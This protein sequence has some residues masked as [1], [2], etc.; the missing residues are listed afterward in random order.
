MSNRYKLCVKKRN[1]DLVPIR[2]D[3]IT[4][5]INSL[6]EMKPELDSSIDPFEITQK[7]VAMIKSDISTSEIDTFTAEIC[8]AKVMEHYHYG[9]LAARLVIDDHHKTL[10]KIGVN[11]FSDCIEKLHKNIDDNGNHCSIISDLIYNFVMENKDFVDSIPKLEND[12]LFDYFGFKSMQKNYLLKVNEINETKEE[13]GVIV[14]CPQYMFLRVALAIHIDNGQDFKD[15]I[16]ETYT[17]LSNKQYTHATPTLYNA[18]TRF[19]NYISC[20]LLGMEDSI[21]GIFKCIGDSAIIS[22]WAGGIGINVCDIRSK[23]SYISK[24]NGRSDGVPKMLEVFNKAAKYANQCFTPD[25]IIYTKNGPKEIKD[26]VIGDEVVTL[27]GEFKPVMKVFSRNVSEKIREIEMKNGKIVKCTDVHQIY[28][29]LD[30]EKFDY[31]DAKELTNN[32]FTFYPK[33]TLLGESFEESHGE[34]VRNGSIDYTGTVY[35]LNIKDNHNYLTEMGLVHNSGK[36]A[37]S[38]A[39]YMEPWHSDIFEFLDAKIPDGDISSK[40]VDLFYGMWIPDVF[41]E[42]VVSDSDW[43]LMSPSECPGLTDAYDIEFSKLYSKYISM[44]K[45]RKKIKAR[46]LWHKIILCQIETGNPYMLFKDAVNRKSNHKNIGTIKNSNLCVAPETRIL[47]KEGYLPISELKDKQI[48]VWNGKQW[49][50]T[51]VRQTGTDQKLLKVTFSNGTILHCT[52]YHKFYI[53]ENDQEI[54]VQTT[55]LNPGMKLIKYN[56]PSNGDISFS[57]TLGTYDEVYSDMLKYQRQ[58][59]YTYIKKYNEENETENNYTLDLTCKEKNVSVKSV[60]DINRISDTY[61]FTEPLENKGMFE[62]IL[63]GNCSEIVEYS[64]TK[65]YAC[66]VLSSLVLP[67]FVSESGVFDYNKLMDTTRIIVRNLDRVIDIN[68]YPV[69]ETKLSNMSERPLG[70]GVQ[71]L[72]DVFFK[73]GIPF[74]SD[75][76]SDVNKNIFETIYYAAVSESCK[77]AKEKGPYKTYE[78][79]PF[80]KG[81]LQFD[82]WNEETASH[83]TKTETSLNYDWDSLKNEIKQYGMRNSMLTALMPTASTSHLMGT[84]VEAFEPITSN[85]YTR[86]TIAGEFTVINKYMVKELIKEDLWNK[87]I[88]SKIIKNRGSIQNIKEIPQRIKDIYKTCWEIKQKVL[89]DMSRDR[90]KFIDQTQSLNI[91]YKK[92]DYEKLT[93]L[94]IY[95]WQNGLKTGSYYIRSKAAS[96]A[97]SFDTEKD[98]DSENENEEEKEEQETFIEETVEETLDDYITDEETEEVCEMCSS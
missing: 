37:G 82:L 16:V 89:V 22:K 14:E 53:E 36:R 1:G 61:C 26:I 87:K 83:L 69:P 3:E 67:T 79:S 13:K 73:M 58:G 80:S 25:T 60:E 46:E 4:D 2:V 20:F 86:R 28:V 52:E 94:H 66:C 98:D 29:S 70:I 90:G 91:F 57:A 21:E 76:A 30:K 11:K 43:Y 47:T 63:T 27:T 95:S 78:G 81:L 93:N 6:C 18:G 84:I 19:S 9:I 72:S 51:T 62:G 54:M 44:K 31:C 64:D 68:Y 15:K 42:A 24:T 40:S 85:A 48:E 77:L 38:F 75:E 5:R 12:F 74:D 8:I 41:M 49:S 88:Q 50:Q 55:D 34:I 17:A 97:I 10:S 92:I 59:Y 33:R 45:Y 23:D 35:D 39:V 7:V 32:H 96:N 65:K 71:G 56:L